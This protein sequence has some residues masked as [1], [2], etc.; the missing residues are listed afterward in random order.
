MGYFS[1]F[2]LAALGALKAFADHR[3]DGEN[4]QREWNDYHVPGYSYFNSVINL[5]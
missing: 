2:S 1:S 4:G 5:W 3:G